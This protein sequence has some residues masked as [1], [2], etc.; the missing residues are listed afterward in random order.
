L[1]IHIGYSEH[2]FILIDA[3]SRSHPSADDFDDGNW[4]NAKVLVKAG[5]FKG[6]IN[7]QIRADELAFFR[8][9]L[10]KLY[11][12][13]S[14]SAKFSTMEEWLS[15]KIAGDG[16]G[17]FTLT[18]EIMDEV[19]LGNILKFKFDFDQ[20]FIP[21]VLND[22]EKVIKAFPVLGKAQTAS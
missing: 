18:G 7:G 4:L 17:H 22:L 9:E 16:K 11:K 8:D 6:A 3:T 19:G 12:S 5:S 2:E 20:T 13:L 1:E 10:T 21:K 15:L 14:G